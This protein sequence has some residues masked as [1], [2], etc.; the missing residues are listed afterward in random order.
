MTAAR[1]AVF[2]LVGAFALFL[3]FSLGE[4]LTRPEPPAPMYDVVFYAGSERKIYVVPA[5]EMYLS[6]GAA[7]EGPCLVIR[8]PQFRVF[9]SVVAV[10]PC[11][12]NCRVTP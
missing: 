1:G 5:T 10:Y 12:Q 7:A 6:T 9:C 4:Y 2:I 11:S 8:E 3:G